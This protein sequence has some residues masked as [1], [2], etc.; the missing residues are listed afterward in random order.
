MLKSIEKNNEINFIS[1][2][3]KL[4]GDLV[5]D[6]DIRIDGHLNGAVT[7]QGR[8]VLGETGVLE[9]EV[10][11][12]TGIIGGELKASITS[13]ELLTLKSTA[14]LTGEI[15]AGKL[16]IEPGAVFSGKCSMGP[17]LKNISKNTEKTVL[18][19]KEKTA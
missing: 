10:K 9:G 5:S 11:C 4:D 1:K 8:L 17:V 13:E 7:T 14:R 12:N 16:A 2:G 3:S 6:G 18:S 19:K 15:I